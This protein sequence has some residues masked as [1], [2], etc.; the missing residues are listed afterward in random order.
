MIFL[1]KLRS[2]GSTRSCHC[3]D[4][5]QKQRT[6]RKRLSARFLSLFHFETQVDLRRARTCTPEDAPFNVNSMYLW[7]PLL[8]HAREWVG[9]VGGWWVGHISLS[10]W[11]HKSKPE[12]QK[13][14]TLGLVQLY[15]LSSALVQNVPVQ[16]GQIVWPPVL[17][18]ACHTYYFTLSIDCAGLLTWLFFF[19]ALGIV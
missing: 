10:L 14:S 12:D 13:R 3:I 17:L 16:N 7:Y 1:K 19:M 9:W 2:F 11:P 18:S 4:E 5:R 6:G 8:V 15:S